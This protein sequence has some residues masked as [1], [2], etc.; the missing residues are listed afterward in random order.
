V[1]AF[2]LAG[3]LAFIYH[4]FLSMQL[5]FDSDAGCGYY[6]SP[7][8]TVTFLNETYTQKPLPALQH[9]DIAC[10]VMKITFHVFRVM[11][12]IMKTVVNFCQYL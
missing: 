8:V 2:L 9:F 7:A 6:L 1:K 3:S 11:L 4:S 5:L 12:S 10:S